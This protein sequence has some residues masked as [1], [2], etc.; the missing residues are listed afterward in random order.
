MPVSDP[1]STAPTLSSSRFSATPN[2]SPGNSSNSPGH[3][4]FE[5]IDFGNAVADLNHVAG[6][7]HIDTL[8]EALDFILND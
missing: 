4:A 3:G 7:R 5:T 6:L 8:I 1:I 2:T